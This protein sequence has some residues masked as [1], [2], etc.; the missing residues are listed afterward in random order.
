MIKSFVNFISCQFHEN[1][2]LLLFFSLNSKGNR[3]PYKAKYV[4]QNMQEH[5]FSLARIFPDKDRTVYP[6]LIREN[7]N[8]RMPQFSHIL[9][10]IKCRSTFIMAAYY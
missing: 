3:T 5:G 1:N 4:V 7:S 9:P 8:Q 6:V 2:M 10:S